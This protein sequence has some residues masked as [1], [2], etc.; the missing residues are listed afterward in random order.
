MRMEVH[1]HGTVHL[2]AAARQSDLDAALRPWLEYLDI[3][4]TEEARSLHHDE[5]GIVFDSRARTLEICWTGEVGRSFATRI[6]PALQALCPLSEVAAE[7]E[8]SYYYEE[9]DNEESHIVFVGPTPEAVHEAQRARMVA[10]VSALL[11]RHFTE[12]EIGRVV[13]VVNDLFAT[14]WAQRGRGESATVDTTPSSG[15]R[16]LH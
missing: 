6:E 11:G 3:D 16:H 4:S 1:V 15:R 10:D 5:P 8:V 13:A 2:R 12:G 14:D 9:D 7:V